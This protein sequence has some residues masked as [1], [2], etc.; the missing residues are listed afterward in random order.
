MYVDY[1]VELVRTDVKLEYSEH[2]QYQQSSQCLFGSNTTALKK[3][4]I[5]HNGKTIKLNGN[6]WKD[7]RR[8]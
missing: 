6:V 2:S 3:D 8:I 4:G 7:G 1:W 5:K